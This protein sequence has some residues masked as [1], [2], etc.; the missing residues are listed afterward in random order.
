MSCILE[1]ALANLSQVT[2]TWLTL[3]GSGWAPGFFWT[4]CPSP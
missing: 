2:C 3:P 4:R 1:G